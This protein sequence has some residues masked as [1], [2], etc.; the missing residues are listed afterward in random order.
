[1]IE[2]EPLIRPSEGDR[3]FGPSIQG[4]RTGGHHQYLAVVELLLPLALL[5]PVSAED[6]VDFSIDVQECSTSSPF[7]L[8][9]LSRFFGS[10]LWW[11]R[12]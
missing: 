4:G 8:L 12:L 9:G 7:L 2:V 11:G 1:M 5:R 3:V 6:D 10:S